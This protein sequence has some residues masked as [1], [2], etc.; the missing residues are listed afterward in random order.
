MMGEICRF[1]KARQLAHGYKM[2]KF[3]GVIKITVLSHRLEKEQLMK[4]KY[5]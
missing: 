2:G 5:L 4:W 1:L 3:Q